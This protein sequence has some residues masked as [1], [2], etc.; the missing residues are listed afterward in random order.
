MRRTWPLLLVLGIAACGRGSA[1]QDLPYVPGASVV[2]QTAFVGEMF[3]L[4]R[5]AWEQVELRVERPFEQVRDFYAKVAISGWTPIFESESA[6]LGGRSY[7]R[8]LADARRRRFYVIG[9][10]ERLTSKDVSVLLRRGVAK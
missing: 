4:P 2:G 7:S 1:L 10:E 5:S 3:G 8:F 9:V 6:K